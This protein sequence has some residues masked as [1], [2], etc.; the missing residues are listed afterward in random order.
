VL[1]PDEG[2]GF[3]RPPNNLAFYAITE[4]FLARNLGGRYEAIGDAFDGSSV[5]VPAGAADVPGLADKL[6]TGD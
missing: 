2:H 1:F 3:A 6:K 4:A 5:K